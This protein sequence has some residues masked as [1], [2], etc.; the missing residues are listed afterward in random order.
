MAC[1]IVIAHAPLASS[2]K[3][4]AQHVYPDCAMRLAAIDVGAEAT[5]ESLEP[6]LRQ[7]LDAFPERD[8]LIMSDVFGATPCNAALRVA[9]GQ[10]VRVVAGV[11]VPMVWR[12]LCYAHESVDSLVER[13]VA[14]AIQGV[15]QVAA[16]RRQNQPPLP[17]MSAVTRDDQDPGHHQQ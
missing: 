15:V 8:V 6:E 11:N 2:L 4:V 16:A 13:A 17:R 5:P 7:A 3:S 10:H 14:G 12:A 9:D 1:L